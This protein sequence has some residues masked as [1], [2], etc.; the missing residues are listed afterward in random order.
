MD[1]LTV[2]RERRDW[3]NA[4]IG[5]KQSIGWETVYDQREHAALCWAV[6]MLTRDLSEP[7]GA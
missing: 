2:L 6:T 4:R 3:L 5:A 7:D 1:H